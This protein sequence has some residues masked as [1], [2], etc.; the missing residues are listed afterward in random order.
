M[1]SASVICS[2]LSWLA[3]A[4]QPSLTDWQRVRG[5]PAG[6]GITVQ[7]KGGEGLHGLVVT[8]AADSLVL[9]ADERG[10][11]GRTYRQRT[12]AQA[13]IREV[14]LFHR[15]ASILAGA[16]IGAAVGG[17]VGAGIDASAKSSEEQ[18]LA[19][20]A[21]VVLGGV[22]GALIGRHAVIIKGEKIYVAP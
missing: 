18:G 9:D 17:G 2:L 8:V 3:P 21:F 12:L 20:V 4:Q 1:I 16:G 19:T 6:S 11:P 15:G 7:T 22:L 5:L 10:R 13:D 14:R